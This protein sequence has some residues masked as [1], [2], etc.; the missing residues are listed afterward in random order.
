SYKM[1][2]NLGKAMAQH[3]EVM[4]K[5]WRNM[6]A[7]T[8]LFDPRGTKRQ[9]ESVGIPDWL[10]DKILIRLPGEEARYI[11][12]DPYIPWSILNVEGNANTPQPI[13]AAMANLGQ[14]FKA[15]IDLATNVNSNSGAPIVPEGADP[16]S[17]AEI[18]GRYV[19][20]QVSMLR[21]GMRF[22]AA[23]ES[24][25]MRPTGKPEKVWE[26]LVDVRNIDIQ[27]EAELKYLRKKNEIAQAVSFAEKALRDASLSE[28]KRN[29]R[30]DEAM[31]YIDGL[32]KELAYIGDGLI[33]LAHVKELL[34]DSGADPQTV[35]QLAKWFN[36]QNDP[37]PEIK[38]SLQRQGWNL[39]A[40]IQRADS[41]I[42]QARQ[43]NTL[44][45]IK[46]GKPP[47]PP[48]MRE[49][50]EQ[51]RPKKPAMATAE[52][53]IEAAGAQPTEIVITRDILP[54]IPK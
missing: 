2:G 14:P 13:R 32:R 43:W 25:A 44:P 31:R 47:V 48:V 38:M 10:A 22:L 39:D 12:V 6:D 8:E 21:Q 9:Q 20:S 51:M 17:A 29:Q 28:D 50:L 1:I 35:D 45:P 42:A 41:L 37:T 52:K 7:F 40:V 30:F 36:Q 33:Q 11:N 19:I 26:S 23:M 5:A 15:F 46:I 53:K 24:R 49:H 18:R 4:G 34:T 27:R 3:P 16:K 54:G